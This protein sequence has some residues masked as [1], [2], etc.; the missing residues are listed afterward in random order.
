MKAEYLGNEGWLQR[1][2]VEHKEYAGARSAETQ[3]GKERGGAGDLLESILDRENLNRAYKRVKRNRGAPGVDGMTVDKALPWLWEH[4]D[5]LLQSIRKMKYNPAPVRRKTI[6]K[7]DG[8]GERKLGI[9]TVIDWVIQQ[10]IAQKLQGI[11]EAE[12]L[13]DS[14]GYRPRRSAQQAIMKVKKYAQA[15]YTVAVSI[16]LSKYFDTLNH[17]LLMNL[18][19]KKVQ[20]KRTLDLI[21][22]Y[23]KSGVMEDGVG[24]QDRARLAAG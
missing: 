3:E 23:L 16:D 12:F 22:K 9:P 6:P 19:C 24:L 5:E 11:W 20:D 17:E 4:R 1:D 18:L 8:S 10:A 15:G 14:Y 13:P 7:P 21:K 2:G